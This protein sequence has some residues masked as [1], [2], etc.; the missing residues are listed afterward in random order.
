MST[1]SH[2]I[3][4]IHCQNIMRYKH[5]LAYHQVRHYNFQRRKWK[6]PQPKKRKENYHP[7]FPFLLF[8]KSL[9]FLLF[10]FSVLPKTTT[11]L[12]FLLRPKKKSQ[13]LSVLSSQNRSSPLS[14][15]FFAQIKYPPPLTFIPMPFYRASKSLSRGL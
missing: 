8:F 1:I 14:S 15:I 12:C 9:F 2:S 6:K 4:K 13:P 3:K 11:Q 5:A 7:F 10:T